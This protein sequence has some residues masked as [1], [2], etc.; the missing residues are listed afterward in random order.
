MA[1]QKPKTKTKAELER[2]IVE[3][4]AQMPHAYSHAKE[5]IKKVGAEHLMASGVL[6]RLTFL[7]GVE[8]INPVVI[9]DGLSTTT[10]MAIISDIERSR[11]LTCL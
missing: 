6:L 4:S 10:I 1:K 11:E 9:K 7:G 5:Q 8:A 3:L 2:K